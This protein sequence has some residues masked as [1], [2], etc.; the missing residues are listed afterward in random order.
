MKKQLK[1]YIYTRVSTSMQVDGYSLDAQKDKLHKYADYQDMIIAG[2]Y[3]DEGKSGKS[4]EGRPQFM[5]VRLDKLYDEI[6]EIETSIEAVETRLYNIKQEKISGDNV[7]QFLLFFDK[8][9]DRFTDMEKKTFMKSFLEEVNIYEEEQED[10]RILRSL[11]FRFPVFF[12]EQEL[13]EL[14]WD[15]ESTVETVC[16]LSKIKNG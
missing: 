12:N 6:E 10:G 9:Y 3:S 8:L 13:Y 14:D 2:E 11:K 7:Y 4:V 16:L 15:N 1:C 5:Q